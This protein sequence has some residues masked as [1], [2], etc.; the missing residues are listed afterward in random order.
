MVHALHDLQLHL[1]SDHRL[2][3]RMLLKVHLLLYSA[4]AMLHA[5]GVL[6]AD[7]LGRQDF[8]AL[9]QPVRHVL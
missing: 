6:I 8:D 9:L 4:P 5:D 7:E 1:L 2:V 3:Q